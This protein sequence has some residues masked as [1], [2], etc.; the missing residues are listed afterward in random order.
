MSVIL[1]SINSFRVGEVAINY[2]RE[3]NILGPKTRS[4]I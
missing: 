1:K 3:L 2:K 4:I